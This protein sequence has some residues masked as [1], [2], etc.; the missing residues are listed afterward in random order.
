MLTLQFHTLAF[1][2]L[3]TYIQNGESLLPQSRL[4]FVVNFLAHGIAVRKPII[5]SII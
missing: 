1:M 4:L 3:N 5:Q 2:S